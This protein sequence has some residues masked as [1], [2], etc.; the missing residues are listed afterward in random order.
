MPLF[1]NLIRPYKQYIKQKAREESPPRYI[2]EEPG[3]ILHIP[4]DKLDLFLSELKTGVTTIK[5]MLDKGLLT[6]EAARVS[7]KNFVWIDDGKTENRLNV[8]GS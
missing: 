1:G 8:K 6:G 5:D 7:I 4:I 3:D 2:I